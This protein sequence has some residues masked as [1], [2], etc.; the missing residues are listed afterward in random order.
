MHDMTARDSGYG[1]KLRLSGLLLAFW[2]SSSPL[3]ADACRQASEA[4][5][6]RD[7][8]TAEKLLKQ[9][10]ASNPAQL[11]PYLDLCGVY[12]AQGRSEDL[13]RAAS[14]GMKR[15]PDERRFY[16]TVANHAGRNSQY[17]RAIEVFSEAHRRWPQD[18]QFREG[19][20]SAHLYFGMQWLDKGKNE[21]A[22]RHLREATILA[23][24]DVDAHLNLGR[25]LHNLNRSVEASAEFDR[26]IALAPGTPLAWFH[27]GMVR[28][29][30]NDLDAAITDLSEEIRRN[31]EYPPSY[32]LRGRAFQTKGLF[33]E[34][35]ADLEIAVRKM[36]DNPQA[37]FSRG[38][39]RHQLGLTSEAEVDFRKAME[40]EP[41]NPEPMNALA[42]LL[43]IAGRKDQAELL[44]QEARKKAEVIR[45][46]KP[47]EIRFERS[48]PAE[49]KRPRPGLR[50]TGP[51]N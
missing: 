4:L 25:A 34:A 44:F 47:G 1:I 33:K 45:T 31:P 18:A 40:L 26:V 30:L 21:D 29:A 22:E 13:V 5:H 37:V 50:A 23:E 17:E 42:R 14:N 36:P 2:I 27:R 10:L 8:N 16:L 24:H 20:A 38:R 15:F 9:C 46:A 43:L 11:G 32:L 7:F 39:C 49:R 35:L 19:L 48:T 41:D 3:K 12:Q 28:H 51:A 6:R